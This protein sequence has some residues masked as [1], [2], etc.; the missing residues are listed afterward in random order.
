MWYRCGTGV[1]VWYMCGTGVVHVWQCGTCVVHVWYRR[2]TG[3]AVWS[4]CG[5]C[6]VHVDTSANVVNAFSGGSLDLDFPAPPLDIYLFII[7]LPLLVLPRLM[8]GAAKSWAL[9]EAKGAQLE[10][11]HNG[12][13]RQMM[14][15]HRGPDGPSTAE[16][17]AR[18]GQTSMAGLMR[19]H[20]VRRPGH[21]ARKPNDDV[22]VK[23]L[24]FVHS[25]PGH[26]RPIGRPH[27]T[28]MDTAMHGMDSLGHTLQ[29]DLPRDWAN[30]ALSFPFCVCCWGPRF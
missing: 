21:A 11:F 26:S 30:L 15:L 28:R 14:G 4:M 2:G 12:C 3:V 1:A 24:L 9:T 7:V 22:M 19:R 13:L 29:M 5:P 18:T 10:T 23:Q 17:L 25:F 8:Y 6:V 27:L 20:R 16:L